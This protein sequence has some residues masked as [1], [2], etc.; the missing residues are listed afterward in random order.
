MADRVP[1]NPYSPY[2]DA[3]P[4]VRHL[5]PAFF[6]LGPKPGALALTGCERMAVAPEEK[7][8]DVTDLLIAGRISDLP[9]GL[10]PVCISVATGEGV[11]GGDGT[12]E[13]REC[14]AGTSH[15]DLCALCR[16]DLH[17]EWWPTR[18]AVA[19]VLG[20]DTK[21]TKDA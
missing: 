8:T 20:T 19:D 12:G 16:Q 17:E 15:G 9:P 2:A 14:G 7:L 11:A 18:K 1:P 21:E 13:C 6:G 3:D 5:I 4:D 10:C